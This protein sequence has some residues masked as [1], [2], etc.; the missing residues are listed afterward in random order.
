MEFNTRQALVGELPN[1]LNELPD[2]I[3]K[4]LDLADGDI[5]QQRIENMLPL[6]YPG[7]LKELSAFEHYQTTGKKQ[8]YYTG[9]YMSHALLGGACRSG[10]DVARTIIKAYVD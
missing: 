8:I 9:D 5:V 2:G 6:F 7:Y 1:V 3:A 4:H 10:E